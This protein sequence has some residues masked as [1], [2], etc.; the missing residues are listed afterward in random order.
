MKNVQNMMYGINALVELQNG[1]LIKATNLDNGATTPPFKAVVN[2][3]E[4]QLFFYGSIGRG[5][6]QKS[7]ISTDNYN[8]GR[9][10]I[11]H[12]LG[13]CSDDYT[14]FYINCTT[15][16]MNK[17]ASALIQSPDDIV[18][19]TRMEHHANDLPW[20]ERATV[21]YVEVDAL[22][23]LNLDDLA[24]NLQLYSGLVKY[25]TVT[26]ASNVTG[27]VNDVHK[28]AKMVHQAGAK[29]IVDGAQIVAHRKFNMISN[30]PLE[31][32]DFFVFSAHKMY[33]PFGGGAVVGLS[34]VLGG[35]IPQF[36]G[37]GMVDAVCDEEVIYL[38]PPDSFEAGSP[39]YPG[40]V[41][42]LKSI[43]MLECIGFDE[44]LCHEQK[45]LKRVISGLQSIPGVTL[46]GDS[47]NFSDRIATIVFNVDGVGCDKVADFLANNYAI[48]VRHAAFCAHP[49]V[50][51][52]LR[53][54]T[55]DPCKAPT[56]MVRVSF[57]IYNNE[58]DVD[59]LIRA[60][61][62]ISRCRGCL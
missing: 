42:M 43:D 5:R 19:C 51:R 9:M 32:I 36:Y 55:P 6:G 48:A 49:Y 21:V 1:K 23:R 18:I 30:D 15:D 2:E 52:L 61:R 37:G 57:G 59:L 29:I 35:N 58:C 45:L 22:G 54:P 38:G 14:V 31:N 13:A 40:V 28:I 50:R 60:V 7:E 62:H 26:A 27:Y 20:R 56:G 34:S 4:N 46:Y 11:K 16:G 10:K 44:I 47:V 39:N 53:E 17:L 25:V 8:D 24:Y 12:F 41:G 33:S 3:I